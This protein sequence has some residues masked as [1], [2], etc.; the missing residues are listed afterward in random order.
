MRKGSEPMCENCKNSFD[1]ILK[2]LETEKHRW[3]LNDD[4]NLSR[5]PSI[6]AYEKSIKIVKENME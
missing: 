3:E 1:N 4:F 6:I 2:E 5:V